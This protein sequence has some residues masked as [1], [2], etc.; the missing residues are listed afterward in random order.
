MTGEATDQALLDRFNRGD[1]EA[2]GELAA[3]YEQGLLGLA[4]GLLGGRAELARDAV[5][6]AWVRVIK[7]GRGF[8]GKSS[9]RTWL[10][11]IVI[12]RCRDLRAA[13]ASHVESL[14]AAK[15]EADRSMLAD[16]SGGTTG[17]ELN[18]TLR[19]AV[20][21]LPPASRLILLLSYHHGL[22]H[23]QTAEILEIP[24]GTLKSRLHS[25]LQSLR[26]ALQREEA[27]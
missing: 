9:V 19:R 5:Q 26:Q 6:D 21:A 13:R 16:P 10:Y 7:Y 3:R 25:A 17:A 14:L 12:N 27:P 23:E 15:E 18:G 11:R 20:D 8:T 24:V 2:L 22:T 4:C 1:V